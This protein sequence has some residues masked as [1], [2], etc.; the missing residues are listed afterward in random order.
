MLSIFPCFRIEFLLRLS[1][2]TATQPQL[3]WLP[4]CLRLFAASDIFFFS[5]EGQNKSWEGKVLVT[6]IYRYHERWKIKA[7]EHISVLKP[8]PITNRSWWGSTM[9]K[10]RDIHE[11]YF[12]WFCCHGHF[13]FNVSYN[14]HIWTFVQTHLTIFHARIYAA[15]LSDSGPPRKT[16]KCTISKSLHNLLPCFY[17]LFQEP[18]DISLCMGKKMFW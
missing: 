7:M 14:G 2:D 11:C 8:W 5:L 9:E 6:Y 1:L 10:L 13:D 12:F 17:S 15:T 4:W 3:T 18:A 16:W